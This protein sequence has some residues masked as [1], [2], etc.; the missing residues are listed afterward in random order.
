M[1]LRQQ[2]VGTRDNFGHYRSGFI[3]RVHGMLFSGALAADVEMAERGD[4]EMTERGD[5]EMTERGDSGTDV[6]AKTADAFETLRP[7]GYNCT[8]TS[9]LRAHAFAK[10][11][12][13]PVRLSRFAWEP[14]RIHMGRR[15]CASSLPPC[16][17][18]ARGCKPRAS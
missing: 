14:I 11:A 9:E 12:V 16:Y 2:M 13:C 17:E 15:A 1:G 18:H 10:P 6:V 5:I 8:V 4:I 7:P 3:A